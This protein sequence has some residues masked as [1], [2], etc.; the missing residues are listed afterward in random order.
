MRSYIIHMSSSTRRRANVDR[1]LRDLPNAEVVEAVDG[2]ALGPSERACVHPGNLL[3]PHYP[4]P[5]MPAEIGVF[6]SHRK[7]WQR[8]VDS[9]EPFGLIVEDDLQIDK[10]RF[11][12]ALQLAQNHATPDMYIRLPI[13]LREQAVQTIASAEGTDFIL[14]GVVGLQCICQIVGRGA[15]ARLLQASEEIDRPVDTW[16]QMHWVTG[17]PVHAILPNGNREV[18]HEIGGSTI[19]VKTRA[20]NKLARE[21]KRFLYRQQV[22]ARPQRA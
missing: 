8:I 10:D 20:S 22:R 19:Q 5:L 13:K 18:A 14:P 17:Q 12:T 15:A 16:L 2:R 3:R 4:F 6:E 9:A 1:L 7:C 11:A 21:I